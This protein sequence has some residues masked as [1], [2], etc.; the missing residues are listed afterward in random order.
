MQQQQ[1]EEQQQEEQQQEEQQ[2][3]QHHYPSSSA[4]RIVCLVDWLSGSF[5]AHFALYRRWGVHRGTIKRRES[6]TA[7][8]HASSRVVVDI[9]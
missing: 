2:Q 9:S 6:C 7:L 1:Q 5:P 8:P 4:A 3:Q